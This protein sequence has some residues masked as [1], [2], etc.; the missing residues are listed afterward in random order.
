[1]GEGIISPIFKSGN[2][3]DAKNYRGITLINIL[4]KIY[5]QL[6]VNRLTK[7][8]EKE[9]KLNNTQFGFQTG[10]STIISKTLHAGDKLYCVFFDYLK[11]FDRIDRTLLWQKLMSENISSRF[12]RAVSSMYQ[13]VKACIRYKLSISQLFSS[14]IGLKQGDPSSPLLFMFFINDITQNINS[15]IESIFTIEEIQ[16]FML[17]YADDAVLF[18]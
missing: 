9:E 14:E 18:A 13:V 6:L 3:D 8:S 10:K 2:V 11:A 16:I 12:V 17:L 4:A 15:D 1:M 7:W 5:S